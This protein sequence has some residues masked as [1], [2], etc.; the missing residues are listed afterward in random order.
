MA[1]RSLLSYIFVPVF[2]ATSL[3]IFT[4]PTSTADGAIERPV[5]A[6]AMAFADISRTEGMP[7]EKLMSRYLHMPFKSVAEN[8]NYIQ[9][10]GLR[11]PKPGTRGIHVEFSNLQEINTLTND[12]NLVTSI[13]NKHKELWFDAMDELEQKYAG[14]V[15]I[16]SYSDFKSGR[17]LLIPKPPAKALPVGYKKDLEDVFARVNAEFADFIKK[18]GLNVDNNVEGWF[19]GGTGKTADLAELAARFSRD[20][21]G[22]NVLR[23]ADDPMLIQAA[24]V[25]R[26]WAE[27][28]RGEIAQNPAYSQVLDGKFIKDKVLDMVKKTPD[29]SKI[30]FRLKAKYGAELTDNQLLQLQT[31]NQ[32]ID[33]FSLSPRIDERLIATLEKADFGGYSADASGLSAKNRGGS[34][35]AI[36]EGKNLEEVAA[37]ARQY[38]QEITRNFREE[39]L[40]FIEILEKFYKPGINSG[41]DFA[42]ASGKV[43]TSKMKQELVKEVATLPNPS[44]WR[45]AFISD[46]VRVRDRNKIAAHGEAIEK[47][48]REVL[49]GKVSS[50]KLDHCFFGIDMEGKAAGQGGVGLVFGEGPTANLSKADRAEIKTAF[51][52][53]VDIFNLKPETEALE[54]NYY[55]K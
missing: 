9:Q 3:A 29:V 41:D 51:Q 42:G 48:L 27:L 24:N 5:N 26:Q 55:A 12:K 16:P 32:M 43:I 25:F 33:K 11:R 15:K 53:A 13:T 40:A 4:L 20:I 45:M 39:N 28:A 2:I 30:K 31:Y 50:E 35:R 52:Q 44:A 19:R 34:A 38:E 17:Q 37:L 47:I 8:L 1:K 21:G 46:G 10:A 54:K 14:K 49:E 22:P 6:C 18:S 23:D 7:P 36:A